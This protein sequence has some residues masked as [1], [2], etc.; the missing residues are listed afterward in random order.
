MK[1]FIYI[2]ICLIISLVASGCS[3]GKEYRGEFER[4]SS[5]FQAIAIMFDSYRKQHN[6]YPKAPS[7]INIFE[8]DVLL[9]SDVKFILYGDKLVLNH[10]PNATDPV[11]RYDGVYL[12]GSISQE[13]VISV[14]PKNNEPKPRGSGFHR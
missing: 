11:L 13:G 1:I 9:S 6:S 4:E 5:A 7:D 14:I 3:R 10:S 12:V 8:D 2:R